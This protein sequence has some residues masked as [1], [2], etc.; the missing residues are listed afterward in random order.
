MNGYSDVINMHFVVRRHEFNEG[1][2]AIEDK[3]QLSS[4]RLYAVLFY[5]YYGGIFSGKIIID[6]IDEI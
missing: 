2:V 5:I 3:D 1:Y 6:G 4:T